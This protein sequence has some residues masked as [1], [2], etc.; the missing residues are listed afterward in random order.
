MRPKSFFVEAQSGIGLRAKRA[1]VRDIRGVP[2][3]LRRPIRLW[4][5]RAVVRPYRVAPST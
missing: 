2:E 4:M 3:E 5:L 1:R